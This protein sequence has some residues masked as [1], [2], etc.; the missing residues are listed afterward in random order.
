VS[1][2]AQTGTARE[3]LTVAN[4]GAL[5]VPAHAHD[6]LVVAEAPHVIGTAA[7][8]TGFYTLRKYAMD[9]TG[10]APPSRPRIRT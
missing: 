8:H 10:T 9:M 5:L 3:H 4:S 7:K 1:N 2:A 6:R